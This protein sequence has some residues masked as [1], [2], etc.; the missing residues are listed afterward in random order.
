MDVGCVD[1]VAQQVFGQF[2]C[3]SFGQCRNKGAFAP[4][5]CALYFL[6]QV[7]H[8]KV[9]GTHFDN[10]VEQSGGAYHLFHHHTTALCQFVIGRSGTHIDDL[11]H[12]LAEL[13]KAQRAV[14]FGCRQ[15][16]TIL[17]QG[18]FARAV[19]AIHATD[20]RHADVAF[21]DN[22]Q[23]VL[24][25]EVEQTIRPCAGGASVKVAR[26]VLDAAAMPQLANHFDVV[27]NALFQ[28]FGF[29]HFALGFEFCHLLH[30]VVLNGADGSLLCLFGSEK[31]VGGIDFILFETSQ[32]H[33]GLCVHFFDAFHLVSPETNTQDVVGISQEHVH[34]VSLHTEVAGTWC[35]VVSHVKAIH[36][37]SQ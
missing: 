32:P 20:L 21:V 27:S 29:K 35:Q 31:E 16:E 33:P 37:L 10:R 13:V 5:A 30:Q 2:L 22:H 3:H 23:E 28:A 7:V 19:A 18:F 14:V 8:R 9:R 36:E 15:T 24:G 17:H 12:H 4:A 11:G 1:S 34:R 6:H 25:K 26:I